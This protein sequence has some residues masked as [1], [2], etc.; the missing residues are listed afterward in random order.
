[1]FEIGT[2]R[3]S[4]HSIDPPIHLLVDG[5]GEWRTWCGGGHAAVEN[6]PSQRRCP[7]CVTLAREDLDEC[8]VEPSE[9]SDL[10][11]FL[12]RVPTAAP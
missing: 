1:M 7:R 10:D 12:G 6:T 3:R 2:A 9:V 5:G 4:Q 8:G 11:W